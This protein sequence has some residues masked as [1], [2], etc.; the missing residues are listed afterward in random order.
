MR[1][2]NE[3]K[4]KFIIFSGFAA[5]IIALW[6]NQLIAHPLKGVSL[7]TRIPTPSQEREILNHVKKINAKDLNPKV[8]KLAISAYYKAKQAGHGK[9]DILTV[10]DYSMASTEKRMWVIDMNTHRVLYHT[11]VSHGVAS[12]ENYASRFSNNHGTHMS[13]LGLMITGDMYSGKYGSSLMLHGIDGKF[14]SNALSRSI[15]MHQAHY[16]DESI[17]RRVGRLGRSFGCLALSK[18]VAADVMHTVK[19][20][21]YIFCY[22]PDKTWLRESKFI[23]PKYV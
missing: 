10:V 9:K 8:L 11:L 15:V 17:V 23:D 3:I 6:C 20:G 14:N 5:V 1:N 2:R 18:R 16:V 13:S 19:G 12:G 22:Y 4:S 7:I 21:S